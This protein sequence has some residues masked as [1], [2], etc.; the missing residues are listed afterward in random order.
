MTTV[1]VVGESIEMTA[2]GWVWDFHGVFSTREAAVARC[3]KPA[4][5]VGPIGINQEI[6]LERQDHW[7]DAFYPNQGPVQ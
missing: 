2:A 5:W 4:M 1:W 7:P 3:V 6:P